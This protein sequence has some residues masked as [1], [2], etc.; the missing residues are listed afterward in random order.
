MLVYNKHLLNR[1]TV[2]LPHEW[3]RKSSSPDVTSC[4]PLPYTLV[5]THYELAEFLNQDIVKHMNTDIAQT[6]RNQDR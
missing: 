5:L 4:T 1:V 3:H 2:Y 6:A